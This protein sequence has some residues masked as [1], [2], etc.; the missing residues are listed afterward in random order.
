[1][2]TKCWL[3]KP[4][5]RIA[6]YLGKSCWAGLFEAKCNREV[7]NLV[8]DKG[9]IDIRDLYGMILREVAGDYAYSTPLSH[10]KNM[11]D[12]IF[13]FSKD[14]EV[15]LVTEY[16]DEFLLSINDYYCDRAGIDESE[17]I[18]EVDYI[19]DDEEFEELKKDMLFNLTVYK[20]K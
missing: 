2:G 17:R 6:L 12:I 7:F 16:N 13:Y 19:W 10:F 3:L 4:S 15:M 5:K 18:K 20:G 8:K 1:M 9:I 14:E 11:A